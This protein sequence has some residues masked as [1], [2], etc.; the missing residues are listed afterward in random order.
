MKKRMKALSAVALSA[1]LL[2]GCGNSGGG[3]ASQ[4]APSQE[5]KAESTQSSDASQGESQ[6][7]GETDFSGV[8][9]TFAQDLPAE[10]TANQLTDEIIKEWE[11]ATGATIK[12]EKQPEDYRV[13]LTT[14]FTANQG[15]DVYT[16]IIYDLTSDYEAGYL[17]NFKDLYEQESPY[18]AGK[19]WKDTLP[20]SIRERMYMTENDVPGY[21]SSTSVVRIFYNKTLF[22]K[23]GAKVPETWSE[24]MDVCSKL[25]EGGDTPFAFPNA[26]KED[27]SWL[28]FNNSV[29]SQLNND[30]VAKID[31]SGNGFIELNEMVK[32]FD[33]G[34][35]DFTTDAVKA[36]FDLMKEFSQYWTSDYNGLDQKTAIDMFIRGEVAMVQAMSTNLTS[37]SANVGDSFEYGVMAIPVITAETSEYAMGKSVILG[38]QPDIIFAIN[39]S[40][41]ADPKKLAAAIDFAQ[42]MSSPDVQKKF[43]EGINRIPL[44]TSTQLPDRLSGFI[45]TEEPLRLAYYTGVNS[46]L[47]DFFCRGGQMYLEGS[48]DTAAFA[49]YVQDAFDT[50]FESVKAEKGWSAD[51]NYGLDAN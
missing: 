11:A 3:T 7:S 4:S 37:I 34:T 21:P 6:A 8:T 14:Q 13:W 32:A 29:C 31:A 27:L 40:C 28:W 51:N 35:L 42:Y 15:P 41:E 19:A 12:F 5:S 46:E 45:I 26:S 36:S 47:R 44:S 1:C 33:E 9:L 43:A 38:G 20:D 10:E 22:D 39:K 16:G 17:Y 24:F 50:V 49:Q 23:V 30:L 18:D 2:A 48:Y 25:K